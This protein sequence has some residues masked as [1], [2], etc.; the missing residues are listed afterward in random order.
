MFVSI[1][2][3]TSDFSPVLA[4]TEARRV[5]RGKATLLSLKHIPSSVDTLVILDSNGRDIKGEKIDGS[6]NKVCVRQISG[7]CVSAT[8][9]AMKEVN[10]NFPK[11]K[12]LYFG[13][14]TNDHLHAKL[15]PGEKTDYI[16]D[17]DAAARK[18]FPSARISFI[19]PFSAIKGIGVG[20]VKDLGNAIKAS[21]VGWRVH[22]TPSMKGKLDSTKG[23]H[24]N[25]EGKEIF[26]NWL[27]KVIFPKGHQINLP[28]KPHSVI[29]PP[30]STVSPASLRVPCLAEQRDTTNTS[31]NSYS[32]VTSAPGELGSTSRVSLDTMLKDRLFDLLMGQ[33]NNRP[34]LNR[35]P[36]HY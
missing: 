13:L 22:P 9:T 14:G 27:T 2:C 29:H 35:P 21:G 20:F 12:S 3:V 15:H 36:W 23:I 7:L 31:G 34:H 26:T 10:L 32:Q 19:L 33:M 4:P 1:C 5:K 18:V 11:I 28:V 16:K 25:P 24:L 6:S 8:T 17:L 30:T